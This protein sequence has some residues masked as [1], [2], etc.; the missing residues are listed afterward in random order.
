MVSVG[1][2]DREVETKKDHV[3]T[4]KEG[5]VIPQLYPELECLGGYPPTTTKFEV[6]FHLDDN[7]REGKAI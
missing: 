4:L 1:E 3:R 6:P 2:A 5:S 7:S